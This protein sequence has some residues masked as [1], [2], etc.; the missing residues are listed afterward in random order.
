MPAAHDF[1][2]E[3]RR[4]LF[5]PAVAPFHAALAPFG[6]ALIRVSLGLILM[7]HGYAKLFLSDAVPTSRNFVHFGWGHPLVW[8]YAIGALE[9]FGGLMLALGLFT[10]VIAA[11][12][13]IEMAVISFAVLFP[14]WSW[15]HHGM[16]YALLMGLV[17][18]GIFF[19]GGGRY[20][21]DHLIGREF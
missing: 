10:R 17:A 1:A 6:Y 15:G 18:L 7:P 19:Q 8:A 3:E 4:K 2:I 5:V 21:L 20:S 14:N 13:V 16:E 12:F 11:A 9:F